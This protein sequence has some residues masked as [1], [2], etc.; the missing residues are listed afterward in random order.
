MTATLETDA[1]AALI[2]RK[3]IK[4]KDRN[5]RSYGLNKHK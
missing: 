1:N 3:G 5:A 2:E 4:K